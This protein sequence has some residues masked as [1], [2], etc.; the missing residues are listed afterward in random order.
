MMKR[1][2]KAAEWMNKA[3]SLQ[4]MEGVLPT[5]VQSGLGSYAG[6]RASIGRMKTLGSYG[7]MML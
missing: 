4:L 6:W 3:G 2:S 5:M 1:N 7:R